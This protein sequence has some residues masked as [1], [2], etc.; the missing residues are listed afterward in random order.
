MQTMLWNFDTPVTHLDVV[1]AAAEA[2]NWVSRLAIARQL[3][4]AKSPSLV[5]KITTCVDEGLLA[6]ELRALPNGVDMHV[7]S[8]TEK[9]VQWLLMA[10]ESA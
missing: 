6:C 3:R 4:R 7:Y 1:A 8:V 10:A 5:A 2:G 9:G